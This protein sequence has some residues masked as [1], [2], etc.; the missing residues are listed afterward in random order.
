MTL[1]RRVWA[2][3]AV[4]GAVLLFVPAGAQAASISCSSN[5]GTGG[6]L[7]EGSPGERNVF[8]IASKPP[9]ANRVGIVSQG[10]N[11][12]GDP[13]EGEFVCGSDESSFQAVTVGLGDGDD[14]L[15]TNKS[16][17]SI[18]PGFGDPPITGFKP[19]FKGV[20]LV[21]TGAAGKDKIVGHKGDGVLSG[22]AGKDKIMDTGGNDVIK[23]DS[24]RDKVKANDGDA[25]L[26][27][28][29]RKDTIKADAADT[30]RGC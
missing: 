12:M 8:T 21:A 2:V 3:G 22:G 19:L 17:P 11:S 27:V 6:M 30:L 10:T 9:Q 29:D 1:R 25:D 24:G 28:C 13:I 16:V 20:E 18:E 23:G 15:L 7:V 5:V 26:I 4:A 14:K